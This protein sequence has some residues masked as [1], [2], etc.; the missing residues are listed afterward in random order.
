MLG[1]EHSAS[2]EFHLMDL[3]RTNARATDVPVMPELQRGPSARANYLCI[4]GTGEDDTICPK[5]DATHA[6][7]VARTGDHHFDRNYPAIA[8]DIIHALPPNN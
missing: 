8:Q 2:F 1:A 3:V 6:H 7:V 5:L 4:Y